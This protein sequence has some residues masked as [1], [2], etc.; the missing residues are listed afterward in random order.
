MNAPLMPTTSLVSFGLQGEVAPGVLW[1]RLPLPFKPED[2]INVWLLEDGEGF[3]LVDTGLADAESRL[4]WEAAQ[5]SALGGRPIKRVFVTHHHPDHIGLAAWFATHHGAAI[6]LP[7]REAE[8]ARRLLGVQDD[9]ALK[10]RYAA[11]GMPVEADFVELRHRFYRE[12]VAALPDEIFSVEDEARF[13]IGGVEWIALLAG[14]HTPA[15]LLLHCPA[16]QL[17]IAGDHI[18]PE[19]V[20]NIGALSFDPDATPVADYFASLERLARL[21]ADTLVLPAHGLPFH[22][23]QAR[24]EALA[25]IHHEHLARVLAA[26]A[27]A[28]TVWG[29]LPHIYGREMTGLA[30]LLA[31]NQTK[32]YL[33]HLVAQRRVLSEQDAAG[34]VRYRPFLA[35]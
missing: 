9:A 12:H 13:V 29:L 6:H 14:G 31:F 19:I 28:D 7:A 20:T 5:N 27:H 1:L 35:D 32:A 15:H 21:P 34:I 17:L 11:H 24:S 10:A 26:T 33:D 16:R 30:A 4:L 3:V 8:L 2:H 25:A 23:L 22:G 18:L